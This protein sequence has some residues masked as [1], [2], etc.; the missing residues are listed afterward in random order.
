MK[1]VIVSCIAEL[2]KEKF[3]QDQW[4]AILKDVE[5]N[6]K[7]TYL[8]TEDVDDNIALGIIDSLCKTLNIT[9]AQA[10]DAFGEHWVNEFAPRIY[11]A[12]YRNVDN[13]KDFLLNMDQIHKTTTQSI[14]NAHPPRFDYEWQDDKTLIM[15]YN[16]S[17]GLIDILVGLVKGVGIYFLDNLVVTKL[18]DDRIKIV[19]Q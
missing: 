12:Y 7:S 10:A 6:P 19:F 3:G 16:S 13:A 2:V 11:E 4:D 14:P 5:G 8:A 15:K 1:G 9:M 18:S 17:R